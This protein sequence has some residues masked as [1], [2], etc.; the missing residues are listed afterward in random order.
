[1]RWLQK[2]SQQ[3]Q[4]IGLTQITTNDSLSASNHSLDQ[5]HDINYEANQSARKTKK[6]KR[7]SQPE[8]FINLMPDEM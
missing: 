7:V 3:P 4:L 2:S 1:M 8:Y 6:G 5:N